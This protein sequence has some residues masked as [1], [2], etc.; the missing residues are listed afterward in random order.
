MTEADSDLSPPIL[1]PQPHKPQPPAAAAN[2]K[3]HT[4]QFKSIMPPFMDAMELPT[5]KYSLLIGQYR[6]ILI[7][8]W[9][10]GPPQQYSGG[11]RSQE[12]GRRGG[13]PRHSRDHRSRPDAAASFTNHSIIDK[14]KLQRMDDLDNGND[15]TYEDD[16]FDYNKKLES[17]DD[18]S[19]EQVN[20]SKVSDSNWA[21]QIH[22]GAK[23]GF[24]N[25]YDDFKS[26]SVVGFDDEDR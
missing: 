6:T 10:A 19:S 17:D 9:F 5:G 15:W 13:P 11:R 4:T 14:E 21:D 16:D 20:A 8:D 26:K 24:N 22:G 18:E 1:P 3:S 2:S 7:S 25:F 12:G 23:S